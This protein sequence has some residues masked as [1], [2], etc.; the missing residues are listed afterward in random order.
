M[1]RSAGAARR[2]L[3]LRC[4]AAVQRELLSVFLGSYSRQFHPSVRSNPQEFRCPLRLRWTPSPASIDQQIPKVKRRVLQRSQPIGDLRLG[5]DSV[6]Q[7]YGVRTLVK[8]AQRYQMRQRS[9]RNDGFRRR[10]RG[11]GFL[12]PRPGQHLSPPSL[13]STKIAPNHSDESGR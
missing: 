1:R 8:F 13:A 10:V 11:D 7:Q 9:L 12:G 5:Q 3:G 2:C 4:R 6:R